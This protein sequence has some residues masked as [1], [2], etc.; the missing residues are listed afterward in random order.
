MQRKC[1]KTIRQSGKPT[2]GQM[3]AEETTSRVF[4]SEE[5]KLPLACAA[6]VVLR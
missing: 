2:A 5:R 6:A 1:G 4:A 3:T